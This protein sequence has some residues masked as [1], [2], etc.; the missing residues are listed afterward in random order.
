MLWGKYS[1][2]WGL[3]KTR[4]EKEIDHFINEKKISPKWAISKESAD[5][6]K[7]NVLRFLKDYLEEGDADLSLNELVEK[8]HSEII[9]LC[10]FDKDTKDSFGFV[11]TWWVFGEV[12]KELKSKIFMIEV[13]N[14]GYKRTK[15][16][17]KPMPND[18]YRINADGDIAIEDGIKETALDFLRDVKWD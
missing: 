18:L 5:Q 14:I 2:E 8:Y 15:R 12:A 13:D 6:R 16:G 7:S 9:D 4:C 10:K 17:E 3:L 1:S 11:N